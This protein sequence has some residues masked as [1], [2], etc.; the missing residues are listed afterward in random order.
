MSKKILFIG[1]DHFGLKAVS[2]LQPFLEETPHSTIA[3]TP[4]FNEYQKDNIPV[5]ILQGEDS[6]TTSAICKNFQAIEKAIDFSYDII[7]LL[8]QSSPTFRP[9]I[10]L[11]SK[12]KS[13]FILCLESDCDEPL[14][15]ADYSIINLQKNEVP[16]FDKIIHLYSLLCKQEDLTNWDKLN[17]LSKKNSFNDMS[18]ID[19]KSSEDLSKEIQKVSTVS[20]LNQ[21]EGN[22]FLLIN[23]EDLIDELTISSLLDDIKNSTLIKCTNKLLEHSKLIVLST[24]TSSEKIQDE[25]ELEIEDN[26]TIDKDNLE[27]PTFK[28]KGIHIDQGF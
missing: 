11:L 28:R 27:I 17:F 10:Y 16:F 26:D 18:I 20:K 24:K 23:S 9:F 6:L 8:G 4:P 15:S 7:I 3:I 14:T 22:V 13:T 21:A 1:V 25:L 2:R 5:T 19:M 12:K